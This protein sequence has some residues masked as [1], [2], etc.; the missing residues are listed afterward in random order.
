ML[1]VELEVIGM[2]TLVEL[3]EEYVVL[4]TTGIQ[5]IAHVDLVQYT[6]AVDM[7]ITMTM[8]TVDA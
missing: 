5:D 8:G 4:E 2:D 7:V 1:T 3:Q 6:Q